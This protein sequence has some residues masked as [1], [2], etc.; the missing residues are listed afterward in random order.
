MD[1]L[2]GRCLL[3]SLY[4]GRRLYYLSFAARGRKQRASGRLG[5]GRRFLNRELLGKGKLCGRSSKIN[6]DTL[7]PLVWSKY[8]KIPAG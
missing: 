5:F 2:R 7:M 3:G 6:R 1:D 8:P 4:G